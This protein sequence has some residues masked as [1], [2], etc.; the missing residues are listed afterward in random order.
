MKKGSYVATPCILLLICG[1]NPYPDISSS[2]SSSHPIIKWFIRKLWVQ[3]LF[4]NE[5]S[6]GEVLAAIGNNVHSHEMIHNSL[7]ESDFI[8]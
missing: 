3:Y 7:T 6:G 1:K 5:I 8:S 4:Y 2:Y